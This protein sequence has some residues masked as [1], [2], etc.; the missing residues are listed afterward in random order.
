M[1]TST[2]LIPSTRRFTSSIVTAQVLVQIGAFSLPALLPSYIA[3]WHLSKTEAGWLVGIFF[4][5]YV[6]A[7]PVLVALTDRVATRNVYMVGAGMTAL[8]HLGFAFIAD[9]FWWALLFRAMAG[10]GWAGAYMPGLKAIADTLEGDAQSRAVSAHAAGVGI[11]GASSFA[12]A[13]LI[14]GVFGP[15]AAFLF[16]GICA[17]IAIGIA[18]FV[19]PNRPAAHAKHADPPALLDF[20]PVFRNRAAMAWIAGYTFHTWEMAGLRA[21][22]VTFLTLTA[23]QAGAPRWLPTPTVL[24][25]IAGM[26]GIAVSIFGNEM[27]QRFGRIRIVTLAMLI[28]AAL[29]LC[30]GWTVGQSEA[31]AAV[32]IVAW[33]ASIFL[34]S[35]ALTAGTV[36]AANPAL[37]GATMG[38]HSMCGYA[39]G[40]IGPLGVGFALDLA[41]SNSTLGWGLG[42]G[43]LAIISLIGLTFV[44]GLGG[45]VVSAKQVS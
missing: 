43:Q 2:I 12:V 23:A 37:R 19:M 15:P 8:A 25:T 36:Q 13:G 22:G 31:L 24:F 45:R 1:T 33:L 41:S 4:A 9:N 30:T 17:V 38:L 35:A 21:W 27:S 34:D 18:M 44:R 39:G 40:F 29:G 3:Q 42:F 16:G 10:I 5:A 28:S 14:A 7:V 32:L 11:A 6:V 26:V 20:R